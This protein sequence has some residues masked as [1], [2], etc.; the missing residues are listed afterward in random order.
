MI[1]VASIHT[2]MWNLYLLIL[3]RLSQYHLLVYV[4]ILKAAKC[5]FTIGECLDVF[6]INHRCFQMRPMCFKMS[7]SRHKTAIVTTT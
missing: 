2:C 4:L 5:I 3:N 7:R 1:I 6:Q